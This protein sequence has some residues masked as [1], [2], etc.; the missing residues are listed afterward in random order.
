MLA[1][2][3]RLLQEFATERKGTPN[4]GFFSRRG[5]ASL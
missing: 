5:L 1:I 4:S 3:K 2:Q